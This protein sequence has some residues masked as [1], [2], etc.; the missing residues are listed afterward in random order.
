MHRFLLNCNQTKLYQ[1][2]GKLYLKLFSPTLRLKLDQPHQVAFES[3]EAIVT[4]EKCHRKLDKEVAAI[5][6]D[7]RD[8][9]MYLYICIQ[10]Y[11][12][13]KD[14]AFRQRLPHENEIGRR[15][16]ETRAIRSPLPTTESTVPRS[17]GPGW[18]TDPS[19]PPTPRRQIASRYSQIIL[20]Q[21]PSYVR[22]LLRNK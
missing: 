10:V 20:P 18:D 8:A 5:E 14:V 7:I 2:K 3:C 15:S 11:K 17:A 13:I 21:L 6:K 12:Y 19:T 16:R 1:L 4:A 22:S 9:N